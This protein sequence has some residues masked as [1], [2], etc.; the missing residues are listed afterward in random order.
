[1]DKK[2]HHEFEWRARPLKV[3]VIMTGGTIAKTYH[4]S[5][6]KLSNTEPKVRDI[7]A[8]LRTDDL[9]FTFHD[10]MHL[11]SLDIGDAERADIVVLV[12]KCAE[13]HDAVLVTHGTDSMV[14]SGEAFCTAI[15]QPRVPVIFTGAMVPFV[16]SGSDAVQNIT[17]SLLALR[18]V[19]PGTFVVFHNSI[20]KLPGARKNHETQTFAES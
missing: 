15:A 18:F 5:A 14:Q 11:D 17:E 9:D 20:L 6:A 3:A 19:P 13:T 10:L 1:M 2:N 8:S 12:Q 7:I 4:P 16:I